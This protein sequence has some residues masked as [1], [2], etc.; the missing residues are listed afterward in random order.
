MTPVCSRAPLR[1]QICLRLPWATLS[2]PSKGC[3]APGQTTAQ[4]AAVEAQGVAVT[5]A[6][7]HMAGAADPDGDNGEEQTPCL[8]G[9]FPVITE[10]AE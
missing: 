9:V 5:S 7:G 2:C 4:Q 10:V 1:D 3:Q 6:V 8:S